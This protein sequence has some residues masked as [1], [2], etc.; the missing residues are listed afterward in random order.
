MSAVPIERYQ[1]K[2]LQAAERDQQNHKQMV[3]AFAIEK[4]L[5]GTCLMGSKCARSRTVLALIAALC[6]WSPV[7]NAVAA[8]ITVW[9]ADKSG[10]IFVDVNGEITVGA[11]NT[12]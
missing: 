6:L 11:V 9:P 12:V 7:T 10:R 5:I 3:L 8:S 2:K 1:A 4:S